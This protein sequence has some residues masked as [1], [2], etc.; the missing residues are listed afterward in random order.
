MPI[1]D[2]EHFLPLR[3]LKLASFHVGSAIADLLTSGVWNRVMVVDL[4]V[5]ASPVALLS[6]LRYLL[7]PIALWAGHL[8]DRR[9]LFGR[10]RLSY[11]WLGRL[12]MLLATPLLPTSALLI[13][14]AGTAWIGWT[15]ASLA[16]GMYGAGTLVSGPVFLALVHDVTSTERRPQV[17]GLVQTVLVGSFAFVPFAYAALLPEYEIG[18]FF[19]LAYLATI[20]AAAFWLFSIWREERA[21]SL[22][23]TEQPP[24]K[25]GQSLRLI[26]A[27]PSARLY[28][29]FLGLSGI[30]TFMHD[31]V[32]E[33]FGGD[34]FSLPVGQTTRFNT[35]WGAGVL[36]GMI[37]T[38]SAMKRGTA[39]RQV[40]LATLGL[41]ASAATLVGLAASSL[42]QA[43]GVV[44]PIL[45]LFGV[46]S[47]A[48]TAALAGLLMIMSREG[49]AGSYLALWSAVMLLSRGAGVALGGIMRDVSLYLSGSFSE[50]YAAVFLVNAA[51]LAASIA[52]LERAQ[53]QQFAAGCADSSQLSE[54]FPE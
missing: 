1:P 44:R 40:M 41:A 20:A 3:Y 51:G 5:S 52:L 2:K 35:F 23:S 33:P 26:W 38:V 47:G 53:V 6:A 8:S 27:H 46:G 30:F 37:A 17:M 13:S 16:L 54:A 12:L 48:Y 29:L 15:L 18:L 19:R 34:V 22:P 49:W 4:G 39:Q 42:L 9:P 24:Q 11:I 25:L 21:V 28:A 31:P 14:A 10:R 7:A 50:A 43:L 32:L 36:L 45:F